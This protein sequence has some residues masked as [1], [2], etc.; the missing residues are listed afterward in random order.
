MLTPEQQDLIDRRQAYRLEKNWAEA[1]ALK[2]QL[3]DQGI[4]VKD[5]PTGPMIKFLN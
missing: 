2:K 4:E 5:T 3:L 1:D